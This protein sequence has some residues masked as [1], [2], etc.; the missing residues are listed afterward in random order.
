MVESCFTFRSALIICDKDSSRCWNHSL[1]I[2]VHNDIWQHHTVAS[3]LW[4]CRS[5]LWQLNGALLV[6]R[7]PRKCGPNH[8]QLPE[9]LMQDRMDSCYLFQ[10]LTL[11]SEYCS[12]KWDS[13]LG[14]IF[15]SFQ[16]EVVQF[17]WFSSDVKKAFSPRE[18]LLT[19]Y[20]LFFFSFF[21]Y[22]VF[23][24]FFSILCKLCVVVWEHQQNC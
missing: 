7:S 13:S 3:D 1:E 17:W 9:L 18:L 20:F 15:P 12:G 2:L 19:V 22:S 5:L 4:Q 23:S 24:S 6:L 21:I 10:I 11:L 14:S 16:L 8:K